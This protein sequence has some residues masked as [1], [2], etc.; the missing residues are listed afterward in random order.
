VGFQQAQRD[1]RR[2]AMLER[3]AQLRGAIDVYVK[4]PAYAGNLP[5]KPGRN[6]GPAVLLKVQDEAAII[7]SRINTAVVPGFTGPLT[8]R[9]GYALATFKTDLETLR[10]TY[11]ALIQAESESALNRRQ[12]EAL[13]QKIRGMLIDYR[14]AVELNFAENSPI[15]QTLPL[16][17]P[18]PG[19]TPEKP[20]ASGVWDATVEKARL[21][22]TPSTDPKVTKH[23][24]RTSPDDPYRADTERVVLTQPAAETTFLTADGLTVPGAEARYKFYAQTAR[25]NE[26]GGDVIRIER[27]DDDA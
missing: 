20:V 9:G 21:Q 19:T 2:A 5:G 1:Q 11:P 27:P 10:D 6:A 13:Y 26:A 24:L 16:L 23:Q 15:Y 18:P 25:G 3:Y 12:R 4:D 7:W 22:V 17:T 14:K 8:L